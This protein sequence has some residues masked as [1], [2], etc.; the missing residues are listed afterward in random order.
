V[1]AI[2]HKALMATYRNAVLEDPR[3]LVINAHR[4]VPQ[5]AESLQS[6]NYDGS[7]PRT[8]TETE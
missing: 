1:K 7:F 5:E 3:A 6:L 8:I 4:D 2:D